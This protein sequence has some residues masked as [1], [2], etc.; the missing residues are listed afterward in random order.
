LSFFYRADS[1]PADVFLLTGIH[2]VLL[3]FNGSFLPLLFLRTHSVLMWSGSGDEFLHVGKILWNFLFS[4]PETTTLP[5]SGFFLHVR[6]KIFLSYPFLAFRPFFMI[7][8]SSRINVAPIFR[9]VTHVFPPSL[10]CPV[11]CPLPFALSHPFQFP[12]AAVPAPCIPLAI[13]LSLLTTT[14]PFFVGAFFLA[15]RASP[16]FLPLLF[17]LSVFRRAS[18]LSIAPH[19]GRSSIFAS[20]LI[21]RFLV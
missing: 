13:F 20:F 4:L 8:F 7:F 19:E 6:P 3:F 12:H 2:P 1:P 14:P 16:L 11:L 9:I 5:Y 15:K 18:P 10:R 17:S 21:V